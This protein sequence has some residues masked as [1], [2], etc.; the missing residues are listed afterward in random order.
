MISKE[1]TVATLKQ[2]VDENRSSL[3]TWIHVGTLIHALKYLQESD[4]I[5]HCKDCKHYDSQCQ[6][7]ER[8]DGILSEDFF[9]AD[10]ERCET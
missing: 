1:E 6:S 10:G 8:I 5:V 3:V 9:C 7:C 2:I 4:D